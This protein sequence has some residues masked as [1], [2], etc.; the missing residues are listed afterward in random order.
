VVGD[1][2]R[3]SA[4]RASAKRGAEQRE[5]KGEQR[6]AVRTSAAV[7]EADAAGDAGL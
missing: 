7:Q 3:A 2:A 5:A 6:A 4:A 1:Q